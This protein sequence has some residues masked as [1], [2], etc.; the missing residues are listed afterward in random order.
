MKKTTRNKITLAIDVLV[1]IIGV[2]ILKAF[3]DIFKFFYS[4]EFAKTARTLIAM[5]DFQTFFEDL[6]LLIV[7]VIAVTF[8]LAMAEVGYKAIKIAAQAFCQNFKKL[9]R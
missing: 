6:T 3:V 4:G 1:A 5:I 2:I 7:A 8:W 9:M